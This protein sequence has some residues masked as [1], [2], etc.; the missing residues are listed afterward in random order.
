MLGENICLLYINTLLNNVFKPY[1]IST[2][3]DISE[4]IDYSN[5]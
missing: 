4:I 2:I 1:N 3:K 5:I